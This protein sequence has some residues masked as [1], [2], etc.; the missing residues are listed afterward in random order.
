MPV[1]DSEARDDWDDGNETRI[2]TKYD[3]D[4]ELAR[5]GKK[6]SRIEIGS[7]QAAVKTNGARKATD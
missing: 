1:E 4:G 5:E 7:S 6:K 2:L 3:D